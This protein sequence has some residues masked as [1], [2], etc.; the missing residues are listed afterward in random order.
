M[1]T[2]NLR[3]MGLPEIL[4][5]ISVGRKTGTLELEHGPILKR[6][7]FQDGDVHSTWSND[8]RESLGQFLVRDRHITEEQLFRALLRQEESGR[9]LGTLLIDQGLLDEERLR[10]TLRLKAELSLYDLFL[11]PEGRFAFKDG[12]P[13]A[14]TPVHLDLRVTAVILEGIRRVD[15]WAR[16]A[17]VFPNPRTTFAVH[18]TADEALDAL[19]REAL[20]HAQA[21]KNLAEVALEM[22]R[23]EF[24]AAVVLFELHRRGLLSADRV[25]APPPETGD[26]IAAIGD[27]LGSAYTK[28][29]ERRYEA[30]QADYLAVLE[31]DRL[32]QNAKKGLLAV[33]EARQRERV[34]R[35]VRLDMVPHLSVD[36]MTL[37]NQNFDPQE[38]FVLSRVNGQWDVQSILKL[39]PMGEEEALHIFGRLLDREVIELRDP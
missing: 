11:W 21:G 30:A 39:C 29:Q 15:E 36:L 27:L 31:L 5:W 23:S 12:E 14:N 24:E 3:T 35:S 25:D 17:E 32:N 18:G 19:E 2:G 1:L 33:S 37:T 8:P 10:A 6:I 22:R 26:T 34:L 13:P 7:A 28:L 38:G 9:P 4:Q 20:Q 16:I